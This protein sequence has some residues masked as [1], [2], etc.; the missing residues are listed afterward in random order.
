MRKLDLNNIQVATSETARDINR[1]VVLNL[2]RSRQPISRAD[3]ARSSGLQR[4]T[5]SAI[6]EQ[7]IAERW[8]REGAVGQLPRGRKPTFLHLNAERAAVLGVNLRPIRTDV[9]L[10]DLSGRF[11]AQQSF[12]TSDQ[13][14]EFI[15]ELSRCL[16]TMI[17]AQRGIEY[18]GIGISVPG[19]VDPRT[20]RLIFAPNLQWGEVDLKT[21]LEKATGLSVELENAATACALAELWF[22]TQTEGARNFAIVT[23]SE[24][25]GVGLVVNGERVRGASGLAGEFG[26][27]ALHESGPRCQCG[28]YGCWE[29]FASNTA[30]LEFYRQA[31]LSLRN[32]RRSGKREVLA[33]DTVP[34]TTIEE[35]LRLVEQGDAPALAAVQQ[36]AQHLGQ[37]LAMVI[38][39]LAPEVILLIGEITTAWAQIEPILRA[40]VQTRCRVPRLPRLVPSDHQTQPRLRGAVALILQKHFGLP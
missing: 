22:G 9:A 21:P 13:P 32:G 26:H 30:A 16:R 7:L 20:Q 33:T 24:G 2:I 17:K 6:T 34:T 35:L 28:N 4:S 40:E 38:M 37:G 1:R 27:I 36:M 15:A 11:L 8:V 39:A 29:L 12:A 23:I 25:I 31:Q 10:T 19:R 14:K 18:E 3:L 5:V